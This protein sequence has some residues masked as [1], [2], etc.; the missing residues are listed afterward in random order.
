MARAAVGAKALHGVYF[1]QPLAVEVPGL[2][3]E[4]AVSDGRFEVRSGEAN[5]TES[6]AVHCSGATADGHAWQRI[7]HAPLRAPSRAADIGVLYDGFNAVGLQYGPGYRTL[8]QA[9]GRVSTALARLRARSAQE[10]TEVHPADLDDALCMS[11]FVASS[12]GNGETRLPFAVDAALLQGIAGELWAVVA[13]AEVPVDA[14]SVRLGADAKPARAQLDGFKSRALRSGAPAQRHLYVTEWCSIC[15]T[16]A[17]RVATLVIGDEISPPDCVRLSSRASRHELAA[18]VGASAWAVV[19]MAVATQRASLARLP[20]FAL[21]VALALVQTQAVTI[22][23]PRLCLLTMSSPAH[24][25]SWGLGRSARAEASLP[26]ASSTG[27][28]QWRSHLGLRSLSPRR[29]CTTA[30]RAHHA[31]RRRLHQLRVS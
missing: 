26:L 21:E 2:G 4:C 22:P 27:Q 14:V 1:L 13:R 17:S 25:G 6:A 24:T 28:W 19:V 29:C 20:L 30:W 31:S 18:K 9:W 15:M 12:G 16:E 10:G 23:V 7:N 11:A 8:V 5:A 3:V